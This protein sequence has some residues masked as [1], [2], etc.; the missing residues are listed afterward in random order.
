MTRRGRPRNAQAGVLGRIDD[1]L[2]DRPRS[3]L[4]VV[5]PETGRPA[6]APDT[7]VSDWY[8]RRTKP[9]A[10]RL[11][12]IAVLLNVR[13]EWLLSGRLPMR[14]G[15][16]ATREHFDTAREQVASAMESEGYADD[17]AV[18]R[19]SKGTLA[20]ARPWWNTPTGYIASGTATSGPIFRVD[21]WLELY[22]AF[23][24]PDVIHARIEQ[25]K[26][27]RSAGDK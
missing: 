7:T 9:S 24:D 12:A 4:S 6:V 18:M 2:G 22:K 1:A 8:K 23:E 26:R 3:V 14:E 16:I 5:D 25:S 11:Q 19:A 13:L 20:E 27:D 10:E 21:G 17:A 15:L